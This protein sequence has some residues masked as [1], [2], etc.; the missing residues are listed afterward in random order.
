MAL[1]IGITDA[2]WRVDQLG[3]LKVVCFRDKLTGLEVK[4]PLDDEA[5]KAMGAALQG[6]QI[7]QVVPSNGR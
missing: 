5:A 3:A 7:A 4:V 2:Q 6:I 1:E